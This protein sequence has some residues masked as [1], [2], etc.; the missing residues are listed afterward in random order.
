MRH[1][2]G[3]QPRRPDNNPARDPIERNEPKNR[4]D[5]VIG[6]KENT[7]TLERRRPLSSGQ[8]AKN[9]IKTNTHFVVGNEAAPRIAEV[10]R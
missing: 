1:M 5:L 6:A 3:V 8:I 4:G 10:A 9:G 2:R 7:P